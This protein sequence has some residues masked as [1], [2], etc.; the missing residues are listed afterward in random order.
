MFTL[1]SLF[2]QRLGVIAR[3][4]LSVAVLATVMISLVG[5]AQGGYHFAYLAD[6][7]SRGLFTVNHLPAGHADKIII[8]DDIFIPLAPLPG[9]LLAPLAAIGGPTI[10]ERWL[11]LIFTVANVLFAYILL[12][13]LAIPPMQRRWLICLFFCGTI[14]FA[15]FVVGRSWFLAQIVAVGLELLAINEALGN[16]RVWLIGAWLG[17]AFLTRSTTIFAFPFFVWMLKPANT[18]WPSLRWLVSFGLQFAAGFFLPAFFFLYYNYVRFGNPLETGY[19]RAVVGSP[20]LQVALQQ[21]LFSPIHVAKNLY[22]LVLAMPLAYPSFSAPVLTFPYI[23]PSPWGMGIF[24]TTPVFLYAFRVNWR[25]SLVRTAWLAVILISVPLVL[26]YG[27]GW[28][29]FGYRYALDFYPFLFLLT[30]LGIARRFDLTVRV[31]IGVSILINVWGAWW[32]MYG[33][34]VLP[35]ELFL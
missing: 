2:S 18:S 8:G 20:V 26:Y 12:K 30:G 7:F 17:L 6:S 29:Q 31:L 3:V 24:F 14:Y 11:A 5:T 13:R 22:A 35:M 34:W 1:L 27:V 19:G 23:Y 15:A 10:D 32:Q 16:K 4:V 9:I 21:G 28:V 25:E 33:F